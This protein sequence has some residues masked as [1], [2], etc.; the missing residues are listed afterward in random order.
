MRAENYKVIKTIFL[1]LII[2]L[3]LHTL[4]S[5]DRNFKEL[6]NLKLEAL[7][8][9]NNLIK[10]EKIYQAKLL[11]NNSKL[12]KQRMNLETRAAQIIEHSSSFDLNL[13][14]YNSSSRAI[15]LSFRGDFESVYSFLNDLEKGSLVL[16]LEKIE[17][18]KDDLNLLFNL[19]IISRN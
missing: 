13:L 8:T 6:N 14:H 10:T 7:S 12:P 3:L 5:L 15:S 1:I 4:F 18:F 17:L 19:K 9:E 11:E 16:D 2:V